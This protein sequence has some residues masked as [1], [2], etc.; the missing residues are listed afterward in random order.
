MAA[1]AHSHLKAHTKRS[2]RVD[3][4]LPELASSVQIKPSGRVTEQFVIAVLLDILTA[5]YQ[6]PKI[7]PYVSCAITSVMAEWTPC[8]PVALYVRPCTCRDGGIG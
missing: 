1:A 3:S 6:T 7:R 4:V 2:G 5:L 8:S